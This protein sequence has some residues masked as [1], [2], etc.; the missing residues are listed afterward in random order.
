MVIQSIHKYSADNSEPVPTELTDDLNNTREQLI[1]AISDKIAVA[2]DISELISQ[3]VKMSQKS[4]KSLAASLL[5]LDEKREELYF[6][7]AEGEVGSELKQIRISAKLGIAGWVI[8]NSKPLM[9]ND[10]LSDKRFN[11]NIDKN[12]G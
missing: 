11:S 8:S 3:I 7:I 9:I 5:L 2:P 10:V 6:E 12:T 4:L 1:R